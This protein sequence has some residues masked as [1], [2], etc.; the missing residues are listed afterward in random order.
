MGPGTDKLFLEVAGLP[1][2][3]HAWKHF[4]RHPAVRE[5]ILV[6]RSG[7]ESA[8]H[9]LAGRFQPRK[10]FRCV[11]GGAERQDSVW[12][13]LAAL[14]RACEL[15]AIHDGARPCI[16]ADAISATLQAASQS[17]AAVIAHRVTDSIKESADGHWIDRN[18]DRTKLWAVQ[19]PQAFRLDV[20]RRALAA[21]R[22]QGDLVT[23]DTAACERLGIRVQ[24]VPSREP[25]PKVTV[26][27]DLPLVEFWLRRLANRTPCD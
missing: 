5:V 22:Q 8:F 26:P 11:P 19:T 20:I 21:L 10:P 17:G 1:V 7:Q 18:V 6:V 12:A 4:D 13:G 27:E 14:D 25:N 15:V 2:V 24:L 9:E 3:G 16:S 23:D